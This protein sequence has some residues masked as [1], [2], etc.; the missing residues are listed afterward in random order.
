MERLRLAPMICAAAAVALA[1]AAPPAAR[2]QGG[3]IFSDETTP[4]SGPVLDP[5][6]NEVVL[7]D[8]T[9]RTISLTTTGP[10]GTFSA[11]FV[12]IQ[13]EGIGTV[14]GNEYTF[15]DVL[16]TTTASGNPLPL[17][18]LLEHRTRIISEGPAPDFFATTQVRVVVNAQGETVVD[19]VSVDTSCH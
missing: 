16:A 3:P 5:C 17:V 1:L 14:S 10:N 12:S 8:G 9:M 18:T 4:F 2:A 11:L 13:A 19:D 15:C 7:F 6:T